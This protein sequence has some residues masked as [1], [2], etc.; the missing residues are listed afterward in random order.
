MRLPP[1]FQAFRKQL[2]QLG[3]VRGD[4]A[5][6]IARE[7]LCCRPTARLV[8]AI[9]KGERLAAAVPEAGRGFRKTRAAGSDV[10]PQKSA[11]PILTRLL[12]NHLSGSRPWGYLWVPSTTAAI[13]CVLPVSHHVGNS[14][15]SE[16]TGKSGTPTYSR[17]PRSSRL[18]L[19]RL[20]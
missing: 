8:L 17:V 12:A 10:R 3:D 4:P 15:K 5:R 13:I 19:G 6:L 7:Q 14:L 1:P 9:D 2:R 16:V 11:A 18:Q 20:R